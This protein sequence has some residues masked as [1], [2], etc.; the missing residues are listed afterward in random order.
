[1]SGNWSLKSSTLCP[2][3]VFGM[4][5]AISHK[6]EGCF[7]WQAH[8][9]PQAQVAQML[10]RAIPAIV[11]G[12]LPL[13]AFASFSGAALNAELERRGYSI[14]LRDFTAPDVGAVCFFG[15]DVEWKQPGMP[16]NAY[17]LK[18][19]YRDLP[20]ATVENIV[21]YTNGRS[22]TAELVIA[23]IPC[24]GND[25]VFMIPYNENEQLSGLELLSFAAA[26]LHERDRKYAK[27]H[28]ALSYPLVHLKDQPDISWLQGMN[29]LDKGGNADGSLAAVKQE[30]TLQITHYGARVRSATAGDVS[31]GEC[32]QISGPYVFVLKHNQMIEFV[33]LCAPD[34]WRHPN[35]TPFEIKGE[36][37]SEQ[38][39]AIAP[40]VSEPYTQPVPQ[41][42]AST[43]AATPEPVVIKST[44]PRPSFGSKTAGP[45]TPKKGTFIAFVD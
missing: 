13:E 29:P 35:E 39:D 18:G 21:L 11:A 20:A 34:S 6:L 7:R 24:Q 5:Y 30:N 37:S 23:Q 38:F 15:A 44:S 4:M 17:W 22:H 40:I 33:A 26:T 10:S 36:V 12:D 41:L 42:P 2:I 45:S 32:R 27:S 28:G 9:E 8:T 1:M 43:S 25:E 14:R 16:T 19:G 31:R 3:G